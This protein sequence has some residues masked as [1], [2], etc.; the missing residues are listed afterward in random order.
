MSALGKNKLKSTQ[1]D[2]K[3]RPDIISDWKKKKT[4]DSC[5][6]FSKSS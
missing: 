6:F 5:N 3:T 1:N 2:N 4:N